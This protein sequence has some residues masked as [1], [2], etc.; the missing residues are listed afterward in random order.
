MGGPDEEK[1]LNC[2]PALQTDVTVITDSHTDHNE[3]DTLKSKYRTVL[4]DYHMF[5]HNSVKR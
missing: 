1:K 2:L 4:Y 3:L 5:G